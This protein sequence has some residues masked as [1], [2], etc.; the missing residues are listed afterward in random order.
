MN[1]KQKIELIERVLNISY[2]TLEEEMELIDVAE[3]DSLSMM[4]LL[5]CVPANSR[6][7]YE[8]IKNC[9]TVGDLC[10]LLS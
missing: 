1:S 2:N 10:K 7:T 6:L 8:S 5:S 4:R 9:E 3:W